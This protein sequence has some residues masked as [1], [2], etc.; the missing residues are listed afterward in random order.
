M[1][2]HEVWYTD[3]YV[4]EEPVLCLHGRTAFCCEDEDES[5]LHFFRTYH[6]IH[7]A[8]CSRFF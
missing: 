5:F 7:V 2:R 1:W 4:L 3:A 8:W 6:L